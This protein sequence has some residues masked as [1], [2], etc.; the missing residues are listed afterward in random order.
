M[1]RR[2]L[3]VSTLLCTAVLA[4]CGDASGGPAAEHAPSARPPSAGP[5][6]PLDL[7][8][9]V[10]LEASRPADPDQAKVIR[11]W[12]GALRAGNL[13][14]ASALWAVPSKAQNATPVLTLSSRAEV[15]TFNSAL[16]CGSVVI[17]TGGSASGFTITTV[18]LTQRKGA[19]CD[20]VA[21]ASARVAIRVRDGRID[22]WYRLPDDPRA[23]GPVPAP[24]AVDAPIV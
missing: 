7:P 12:A 16:P 9:G 19:H 3:L 22:E 1:S 24:D 15:R 13:D 21:G 18:R 17:S 23:P 6:D 5:R 20:A 10:P 14:G 4:A 8:A 2:L 11:A